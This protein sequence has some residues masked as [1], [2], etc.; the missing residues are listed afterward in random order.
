MTYF[1]ISLKLKTVKNILSPNGHKSPH[2]N[3]TL[4]FLYF[5]FEAKIAGAE[6]ELSCHSLTLDHPLHVRDT[7]KMK[8]ACTFKRRGRVFVGLSLYLNIQ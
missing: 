8:C 3:N 6:L 5:N 1:K 7:L 4:D 2:A